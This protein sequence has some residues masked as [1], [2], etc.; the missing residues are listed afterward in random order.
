MLITAE[1][2]ITRSARSPRATM[3]VAAPYPVPVC[4]RRPRPVALTRLSRV[5]NPP[6]RLPCSPRACGLTTMRPFRPDG[7][8][9]ARCCLR[10][11]P[12]AV[13]RAGMYSSTGTLT[14]QVEAYAWKTC[15]V[16]LR[17]PHH[18]N[19]ECYHLINRISLPMQDFFFICSHII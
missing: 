18:I 13:A 14:M 11:C 10:A 9:P 16:S 6:N 15:V 12:V 19:L 4:R 2:S 17:M 1:Q 7:P 3:Q 8:R 5:R